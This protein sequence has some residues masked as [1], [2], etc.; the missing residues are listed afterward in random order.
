LLEAECYALIGTIIRIEL[1][2]LIRVN[3]FNNAND[4]KKESLL[5]SFFNGNKWPNTDRNMVEKLSSSLSWA[6]HIYDFCC[7]FIHLSPYHDWASTSDIPNLTQ[8]KRRSIV[9]EIKAQQNDDWG[10]DTSLVITEDFG[11]DDLIPFAPHIFKKLRKNLL[12]EMKN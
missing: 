11:F 1:D 5:D 7:A 9:S 10:Y 12:F 2:S 6:K 8:D 4:I 3:D